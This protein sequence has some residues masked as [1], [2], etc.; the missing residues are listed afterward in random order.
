MQNPVRELRP[1]AF[2][3]SHQDADRERS[4]STSRGL[5]PIT[6]DLQILRAYF[7]DL[8]RRPLDHVALCQ[9]RRS[10]ISRLP[11]RRTNYLP[12]FNHRLRTEPPRYHRY[13]FLLAT[14]RVRQSSRKPINL[15]LR[16]SFF[17]RLR[18]TGQAY[19]L[20]FTRFVLQDP[21]S[22]IIH[23]P[24]GHNQQDRGLFPHPTEER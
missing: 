8:E 20:P 11:S 5:V 17:L 9:N 23:V 22:E 21:T 19:Y 6:A 18:Q 2:I 15:V 14:D 1:L 4:T 13:V 7:P 12:A 24:A 3:L 10:L 16:V